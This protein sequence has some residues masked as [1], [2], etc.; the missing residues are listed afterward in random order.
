MASGSYIQPNAVDLG[1][2][3]VTANEIVPADGNNTANFDDLSGDFKNPYDLWFFIAETGYPQLT[4]DQAVYPTY[5]GM[6]SL[7]A[8]RTYPVTFFEKPPADAFWSLTAYGRTSSSFPTIRIGIHLVT[9]APSGT[10]MALWSTAVGA[11]A[12]AASRSSSCCSRQMYHLRSF[13]RS[14]FPN[15]PL[16]LA[17]VFIVLILIYIVPAGCRRL[18][19]TVSSMS[20]VSLNYLSA[21]SCSSHLLIL[22]YQSAGTNRQRDFLT[23]H[24]NIQSLTSLKM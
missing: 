14:E 8:N 7:Q 11:R 2:A 21:F 23:V 10:Q 17:L 4:A 18:L 22:C 1:A 9:G 5:T 24:T 16:R 20:T 12:T 15:I 13:V 3:A 19:E 6:P